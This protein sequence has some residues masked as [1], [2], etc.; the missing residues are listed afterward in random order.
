MAEEFNKNK[1]RFYCV[2]PRG[3]STSMN[4]Y[5]GDDPKKVAKVILDAAKEKLDKKS[6]EDI[7]V[8]EYF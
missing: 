4:G 7:D 5:Q 8:W 3:T 2:N 1:I 6:G